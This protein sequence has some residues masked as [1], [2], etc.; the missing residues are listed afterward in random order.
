MA[1]M[2]FWQLASPRQIATEEEIA[3]EQEE[4]RYSSIDAGWTVICNDRAVLYCDRSELTGWG[5]AGIRVIT[6][7]L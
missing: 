7:S 3:S 2:C 6:L 5:E 1:L 4:V